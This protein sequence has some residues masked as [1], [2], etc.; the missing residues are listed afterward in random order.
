MKDPGPL[1]G[2]KFHHV[3]I[4]SERIAGIAPNPLA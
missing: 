1:A 4:A 2:R 3:K